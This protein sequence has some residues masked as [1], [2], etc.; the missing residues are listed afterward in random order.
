VTLVP[1]SDSSPRG[2]PW[3]ARHRVAATIVLILGVMLGWSARQ[4]EV[5]TGGDEATY[6]ELSHSLEQGHYRDEFL[7]GTPPHPQYPPVMP[8]GLLV[9]RRLFGPNLEIVR[10]ANLLLI[11]LAAIVIGDGVRR[12][13]TPWIGIGA[14]A[15]IVLN[16]ALLDIAGTPL[17]EALYTGV[18][19]FAV[20]AALVFDLLPTR[21]RLLLASTGALV[22][23]LTRTV[24]IS[25][26]AGFGVGLLLRRRWRAAA[27]YAVASG[28]V[29][30]GW[31]LYSVKAASQSI[32][33][34]YVSDL[35]TSRVSPDLLQRAIANARQYLVIALGYELGL[36]TVPGTAVDNAVWLFLLAV[37][38][39]AG[40]WVLARRWPQA[41]ATLLFSGTI[42]L[43]WPWPIDR[44]QI[45]L[46]PLLIGA[47]LLGTHDIA[48]RLRDSWAEW[49]TCLMAVVLTGSALSAQMVRGKRW[50][51][52][53][54]PDAW[55]DPSCY[56]PEDR[57][58]I[59]A[60]RFVRDSLPAAAII[61]TSKPPTIF[62]YSGHRGVPLS[63]VM[64]PAATGAR[65]VL[66]SRVMPAERGPV[67]K[68]LR[69]RCTSYSV[70]ALF[71]PATLLLE[72]RDS[73]LGE[74]ACRALDE[75]LRDTTPDYRLDPRQ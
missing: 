10:A 35:S 55:S 72:V 52:C 60:A 12:L 28:V 26:A 9:L 3:D 70:R 59:A 1:Q 50:E 37:T 42:L 6:I 39:L 32:G 58:M 66:L 29:V 49:I 54:H 75:Y 69:E 53:H 30:G 5:P 13:S 63:V 17:S 62:F 20:W 36:P 71:P 67:A 34:S 57:S 64:R 7:A 40:M 41:A 33:Q 43:L 48:R 51:G 45:P 24:G 16:P 23:F 31:F 46:L 22:S 56:V 27:A 4:P 18:S 68:A 19:A 2:E 14:M 8:V 74:D 15:A 44:Y 38:V 25:V 47:V 21:R 61:A 11:A 65:Y 73:P